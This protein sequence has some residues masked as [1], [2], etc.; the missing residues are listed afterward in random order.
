ML[1]TK[2]HAKFLKKNNTGWML[3]KKNNPKP[4]SKLHRKALITPKTPDEAKKN[5]LEAK[6]PDKNH[7]MWKI[8]PKKTPNTLET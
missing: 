5:A 7:T 4:T 1:D 6:K 2:H 3:M 8:N